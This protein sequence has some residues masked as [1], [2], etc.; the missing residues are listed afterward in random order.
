MNKRLKLLLKL[1]VIICG[2]YMVIIVCTAKKGLPPVEERVYG[3]SQIWKKAADHYALW[4]MADMMVKYGAVT[5]GGC[6][7]GSSVVM[8]YDGKILNKNSSAN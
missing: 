2:L 7:G 3:V 4:E 5:A 8:A 6:D 1:A